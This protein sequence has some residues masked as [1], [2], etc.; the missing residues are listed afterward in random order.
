MEILSLDIMEGVKDGIVLIAKNFDAN[1]KKTIA[2][3]LW[4][5]LFA[6]IWGILCSISAT[7]LQ[8]VI[9]IE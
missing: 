6:S 8:P 3:S 5:F 1:K 4:S 9:F 2:Y 7:S